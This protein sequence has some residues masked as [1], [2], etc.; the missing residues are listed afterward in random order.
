MHSKQVISQE[1]GTRTVTKSSVRDQELVGK[2]RVIV[3]GQKGKEKWGRNT[4]AL[5]MD[6]GWHS[7]LAQ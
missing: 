2:V 5:G 4:K 1:S 7:F 3:Q 6:E